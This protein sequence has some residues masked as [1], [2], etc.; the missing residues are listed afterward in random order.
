MSDDLDVEERNR[1]FWARQHAIDEAARLKEQRRSDRA[2]ALRV[3]AVVSLMALPVLIQAA[4]LMYVA[5]NGGRIQSKPPLLV[6]NG[7]GGV[8]IIP[9][10][11][12]IH[13]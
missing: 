10:A 7:R 9:Q 5:A 11:P 3:T 13:R 4:L 2:Y 12:T 6:P 1:K 8:M